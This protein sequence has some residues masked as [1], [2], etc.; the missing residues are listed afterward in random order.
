[1]RYFL[2]VYVKSAT[3]GLP[4]V[5]SLEKPVAPEVAVQQMASWIEVI[6]ETRHSGELVDSYTLASPS[7]IRSVRVRQERLEVTDGPLEPRGQHGG[8]FVFDVASEERM[9]EIAS[10]YPGA[11]NGWVE[12]RRVDEEKSLD[13][14]LEATAAT[15][16][17][18]KSTLKG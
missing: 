9:Y 11:R 10:R 1:M 7:T 14:V 12:L 2:Q 6:E 3:Q 4:V 8:L 18:L 17:A 13:V 5:T 16:E 15:M